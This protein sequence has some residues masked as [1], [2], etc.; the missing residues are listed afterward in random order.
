MVKFSW[1]DLGRASV[2]VDILA[3]RVVLSFAGRSRPRSVAALMN[4]EDVVVLLRL[5]VL[6]VF[7]EEAGSATVVL[8]KGDPLFPPFVFGLVKTEAA[9]GMIINPSSVLPV[10]CLGL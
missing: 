5:V 6:L 7:C 1:W 10:A 3:L 2:V 4:G 9:V 8:L